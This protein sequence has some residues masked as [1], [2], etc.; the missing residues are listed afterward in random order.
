[1]KLTI[2]TESKTIQIDE[3]VNARE[4]FEQLLDW[5]IDLDEYSIGTT[6]STITYYTP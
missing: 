1:M 5:E 2:D 4:L 3:S 6:V